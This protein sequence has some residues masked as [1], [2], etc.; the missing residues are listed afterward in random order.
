MRIISKHTLSAILWTIVLSACD[1][2]DI[3]EKQE[4]EVG[5]LTCTLTADFL[6]TATWP[7]DYPIVI[8]AFDEGE[9]PLISKGISKPAL[10]DSITLTMAGI[11]EKAK[12]VSIALLNKSRKRITAFHTIKIDEDQRRNN[13]ISGGHV[14]VDLLS[15][16]RIQN[17]FFSNCTNCHG[18]SERAA[19]GLFLTEGKSYNALV[20]VTSA[21]DDDY[22]LVNPGM[23][24]QSYIVHVLEGKTD[25]VHYDHTNVSFN[26]ES[27]DIALLKSWIN[28]LK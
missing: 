24:E 17:Q 4:I 2:G 21:K 16:N 25:K 9:Y 11:P 8:A 6:N 23:A 28:S 12:E 22:L 19:A 18:A 14:T 10:G 13:F 3:V 15:Y 5:G 1:S 20:G 27:E 7:V 26:S